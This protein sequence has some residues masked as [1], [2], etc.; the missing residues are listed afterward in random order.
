ME[1]MTTKDYGICVSTNHFIVLEVVLENALL[2][3]IYVQ[4][5]TRPYA[6]ISPYI[7]SS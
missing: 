2:Y 5:A 6:K 7:L 4:L 1:A 3:S